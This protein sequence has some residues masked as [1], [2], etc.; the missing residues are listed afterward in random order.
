[1]F[2]SDHGDLSNPKNIVNGIPVIYKSY[3]NA[4]SHR[5][6]P[7]HAGGNKT[8]LPASHGCTRFLNEDMR[9]INSIYDKIKNSTLIDF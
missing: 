3:L 4:P 1:M 9:Y 7:W 2:L 6:N 5:T 8:R